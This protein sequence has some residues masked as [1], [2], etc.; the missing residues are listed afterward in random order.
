[1]SAE[2][3]DPKKLKGCI[4][5]SSWNYL[6]VTSFLPS[7]VQELKDE[8]AKRGLPTDGLKADLITRL[9]VIHHQL[10]SSRLY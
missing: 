1:M 4:F 10:I 9:Q 3:V 5:L 7:I 2:K 6:V 8:L